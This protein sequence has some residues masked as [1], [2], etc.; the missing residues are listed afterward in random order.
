M[1]VA[2]LAYVCPDAR[3]LASRSVLVVRRA[4]ELLAWS[5][6]LLTWTA[7][8]RAPTRLRSCG[9]LGGLHKQS[10]KRISGHCGRQRSS[11]L[12]TRQCGADVQCVRRTP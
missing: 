9:A 11:G 5:A 6:E 7:K 8:G 4:G 1:Q 2:R 10:S 3:A 12:N